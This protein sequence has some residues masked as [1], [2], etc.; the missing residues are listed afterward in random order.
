[1]EHKCIF[2]AADILIPAGI[3]MQKWSV[4]AC[5]QFTSQTDYWKRVEKTVGGAPSTLHMVLPEVW[6]DQPDME[7]RIAKIHHTMRDYLAQDLFQFLK[8][9]YVYVERHISTGIRKG[10]LGRVDLEAYDYR[11]G[12]KSPVR[13]TEGTV[14]SRIP[15]RMRVRTGA[16][17][18]LPHILL[19][20]DDAKYKIIEGLGDR[21][22][23][24]QAL[25]DFDL[26]ED[27]GHICGYA[28]PPHIQEKID[29]SLRDLFA[30]VQARDQQAM[31]IAVGDGNHSLA[32]AKACWEELKK[33]LSP[34]EYE[35]H[36]AR[37]ALV[38]MGT[39]YDESLVF[40]G[41][42]RVLFD[43]HT[44]A[45]FSAL[46][47]EM[48]LRETQAGKG[49][50]TAV[51]KDGETH[52][53]IGNPTSLLPV[54]SLQTALDR[55]MQTENARIDYIH[56]EDVARGLARQENTVAFLLPAMEKE[57]LFPAVDQYG[58]LPRKTFSIG[59][60][61]EKRYYLECRNICV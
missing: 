9:T 16:A 38:E 17:L 19:L 25:Y 54:G 36:P 42:H 49:D 22:K 8:S 27:G 24:M 55:F 15:P 53:I 39:I 6:L 20:I 33:T 7:E 31:C 10:L 56:G 45:L 1:M 12:A 4:V 30:G 21:K 46:I 60:A 3:D 23:E 43:V 48:D 52:Y 14:E 40:E 35:T 28:A 11:S 32:T 57:R 47:K 51:T 26:M 41:I 37:W 18:E 29:A 59:E 50:F 5:D 34:A 13:P 61:H 2:R 58:A 44:N